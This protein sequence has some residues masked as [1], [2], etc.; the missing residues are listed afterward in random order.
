MKGFPFF[1]IAVFF[2]LFLPG[3]VF[4]TACTAGYKQPAAFFSDGGGVV[5]YG[6]SREAAAG[7]LTLSGSASL[8]YVFEP[9]LEVPPDFSLE[10]GYRLSPSGGDA[11]SAYRLVLETNPA[12]P[13][14]EA[15]ELPLDAAF[16]GLPG[17]TAAFRYAVPAGTA[18]LK[19]LRISFRV[20]DGAGG[21]KVD[22]PVLEFYSLRLVPR[23]FGFGLERDALAITPFV[24]VLPEDPQS[25][26]IDPPPAFRLSGPAALSF[27]GAVSDALIRAG[28]TRFAF[29]PGPASTSL[30]LPPAVL[31]T[32][33]YPAVVSAGSDGALPGT[34]FFV[35]SAGISLPGDLV[36][37]DPGV[38]LVYP[39]EAWREARYEVFRWPA[40]PRI[41]IFDTADYAVQE[42]LF[43]RLAFFVEKRDFRGRLVPDGELTGL[44]GWNAHDYRD[45][46]LAHF[47]ETARQENFPL[48]DEERELLDILLRN[49]IVIRAPSG[50]IQSGEG[51]V[52]S[53]SQ[54]SPAHLR[55]RF[56]VHEGFH[57]IFFMDEEFREFSRRRWENLDD[58]ARRVFRSYL[59]FQRY[60]P[61]DPYLVV[62][63]FMAYCLQQPVSQAGAYF[64][65][66]MP[67]QIFTSSWRRSVLPPPVESPA[68]DRS[69]PALARIFT[70][71]AEAF[72]AY[73]FRRWGYAAGRISLVTPNPSK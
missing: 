19:G 46:D 56:L 53:I 60:D 62:N 61:A 18:F 30:S 22:R 64:G 41:L 65:E 28:E 5:L 48:L 10:A 40:F 36:P 52:L 31:G 34:A 24:F 14:A 16:L 69:W 70:R 66:N 25:A 20:R 51:A 71:E 11:L 12:L 2:I 68:G 23:W 44:H 55:Y 37:L 49:G 42:R 7:R 57:G 29:M 32:E 3:S 72:S 54:E 50:E 73:V 45:E 38:I 58:D 9:P 63:E 4:C 26:V 27:R 15:W 21:A 67:R 6:L 17:Y 39:R 1:R 33:P 13:G 59:D 8:S 43:K 47:F 35:E